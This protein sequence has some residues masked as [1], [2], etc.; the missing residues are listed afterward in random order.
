MKR[1]RTEMSERK[2]TEEESSE[3][4]MTILKKAGKP[5]TTRAVEGEIRKT[6]ISCPDTLPVLLN[7]LRMKGLAKGKLSAEH[8]G[9]VWWVETGS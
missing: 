4:I 6:L 2:L 8:R 5:L 7:R 9:W 3:L 1:K